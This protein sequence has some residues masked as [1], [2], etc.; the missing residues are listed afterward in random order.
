M[1]AGIVL[2]IIVSMQKRKG[3]L[4]MR[5]QRDGFQ[6]Q[7]TTPAVCECRTRALATQN[8]RYFD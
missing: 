1:V 2:V 6:H 4:K 5:K 8:H 3:S 7:A